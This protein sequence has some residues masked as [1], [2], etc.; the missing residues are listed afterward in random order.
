MS[1]P[2]AISEMSS[3]IIPLK[4]RTDFRESNRIL[5]SETIRL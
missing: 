3:Q 4:G 5:A 2:T 1:V